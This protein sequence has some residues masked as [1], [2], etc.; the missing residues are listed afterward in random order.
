[1]Y[2]VVCID[3]ESGKVSRGRIRFLI[4]LFHEHLCGK[5]D[6]AGRSH[7]GQFEWTLGRQVAGEKYNKMTSQSKFSFFIY[8]LT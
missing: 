7:S 5:S 8:S 6:A 2:Y 1:M 3:Q 4:Y